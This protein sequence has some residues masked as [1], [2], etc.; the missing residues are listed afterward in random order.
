MKEIK[1]AILGF[2]V[3]VLSSCGEK[4]NREGIADISE[5]LIQAT[6]KYDRFYD[7]EDG[8]AVVELDN[9]YGAINAQGDV[10][11]PCKYSNMIQFNQD[12][13]AFVRIDET[14]GAINKQDEVVIPFQYEYLGE[15][16]MGD[17][18]YVNFRKDNRCGL[19][20]IDGKVKFT[21]EENYL[22]VGDY[23]DGLCLVIHKIPNPDADPEDIFS[24]SFFYTG[25]A[26]EEGQIAIQPRFGKYIDGFSDGLAAVCSVDEYG[27]GYL[28]TKGEWAIAPQYAWALDFKDGVAW[29]QDPGDKKS[30][31][32]KGLWGLIDTKNNVLI[33]FKYKHV[34]E[35]KDGTFIVQTPEGKYKYIDKEDKQVVP[36]EY[37]SANEFSEGFAAVKIGN[38]YGYINREGEVVI[39]CEYQNAGDFSDGYACVKSVHK[40]VIQ[41]NG[42]VEEYPSMYGFINTKG[43]LVVPFEYDYAKNFSGG[44]AVVEKKIGDKRV[45][46]YVNGLGEST[47]AE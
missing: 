34:K 44:Y 41:Q 46:G 16:K 40:K 42:D 38:L 14:Y 27:F 10:V 37:E 26:N 20:D 30:L 23:N 33:P 31:M 9:K 1:Y 22:L 2:G 43:E 6:A 12:G 25:Y 5:G 18:M 29:V 32:G 39:P 7:F 24:Q 4:Q 47:F 8:L 28:N 3:L 35:C 36:G 19:M 21:M 13:L 45:Y 11:I 15:C 17:K